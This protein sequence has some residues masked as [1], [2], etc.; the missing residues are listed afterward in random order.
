MD[1][2]DSDR[3]QQTLEQP[4]TRRSAIGKAAGAG[5]AAALATAGFHA[6][7]QGAP[8]HA[9]NSLQKGNLMAQSTPVA[10]P[11]GGAPTVVLIHG[12]FADASGWNGVINLLQADGTTVIAPP[13]PL[14]GVSLDAAYVASV[15]NNVPGPVLL[16]GH[17]YGGVVITNAATQTPNVVGLVYVAAF[18]P[19]EGESVQ[20]LAESGPPTQ[21]GPALRPAE[22][23]N[24]PAG[25]TGVELSIDVGLFHEAFC[26]DLPDDLAAAMAAG[27]RPAA[28]AGFGEPSGPP[29]WKT[30]PSW[31]VV[32]TEDVTIGADALRFF[33]QRAGSTTVEV[34]GSHVVMISQPDAVTDL[35][36]TA[37]GSV[38]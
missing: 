29:A 34:Q 16:V 32:A 33:A 28:G 6:A 14:R 24:G 38:S 10:S 15:V 20:S 30:L 37:L 3:V 36:R 1:E 35:I 25:E 22:V 21:L 5:A 13:N 19:D 9:S 17:S 18:A 4:L 12:A 23:A 26:A 7:A 27:Q 2:Q 31:F 8:S 11:D